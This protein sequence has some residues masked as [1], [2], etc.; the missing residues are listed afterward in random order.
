MSIDSAAIDD[1]A[2]TQAAGGDP[3]AAFAPAMPPDITVEIACDIAS[4]ARLKTEFAHLE[5]TT[6]N[7]LPFALFEW[8]L[9]WCR[10]FL[11]CDKDA[12]DQPMFCIMR[13]DARVCVAI[14]P[15][16]L[17][18][19]RVAGVGITFI[20][21]LGADPAITEIRTLLV[22]SGYEDRVAAAL[23]RTLPK[24][25]DWDWMEWTGPCDRFG[26]AI[27]RLRGLDWQA[28]ASNY[29]LDLP[30]TW[31]QFHVGLKRNIRESLRHCYNSLK[32]DGHR[33]DMKVA[34]S[35][36]EIH[37]ALERLFVLHSLRA[38]MTGTV[39]HADRFAGANLRRFMRDV[40]RELTTRSVVRI[41][42]LQISGRV[43]ASRIGFVVGDNLYLYYSGFDPEWARYG[44][45]TTTVAEA[46]K[47]AIALG[48]QTV[49]LSPGND[50]SKT[51]WGP[52]EI[53][54]QTTCEHGNRLRSRLALHMYQK[55]K[56]GGSLQGWLL[57]RI[58]TGRR[59]WN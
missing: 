21:L 46:I 5:T 16:I 35:A 33:F 7:G 57:Q 10:H 50:Q 17:T 18:R 32:R 43:V 15:L 59:V 51:R 52:R 20:G 1:A 45:M 6:G 11:R 37:E 13:N 49:N 41:F 27:G 2:L 58:G 25:P 38:K 28:V 9:T 14:L 48:L 12:E 8:Q 29:V 55:A 56:S 26:A 39:E 23:H 31:E 54:H 36:I 19:R 4:V 47:Y 30:M 3:Q 34:V 53:R 24:S 42:E 40:C 22:Q 44:V